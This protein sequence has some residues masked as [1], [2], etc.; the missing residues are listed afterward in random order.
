MR[1]PTSSRRASS[2]S[3][4][5]RTRTCTAA[6]RGRCASTR[7][8][9]PPRRRTQRFR[10]LLERGQT[11]LSVAFDLPT[12]IGYDSDDPRA[13]RRGRAHRRRDRLDR[14]HGA[15]VRRDPARRGLDVDDDQRARRRSCS[16]STSS[17]PRSRAFPASGSAARSRTTSSRST[18]RAGTTSSRRGPRCASSPTSSRTAP[19]ASR[20]GTRSRSRGYHI[21][22]AGSTAVQELAFTLANGIAYVRGGGRAPGSSPDDFA[23]RLSFFFNA[24]NNFFEEVAKFRAARRLWARDHARAVRRDEPEGVRRCASTRRP[25]ARRSRRSSRRTTSCA[26]RS[27]RCPRCCGGAQSLHT[28]GFDEALALPTERAARIALRTQQMIAHE[29]GG[30]DTADPLGGSYFIE[31]LTDE[32]EAKALGADRA[33]RRARRCGRGDRA[34]L[35]PGRDRAG[36]VPLAAGGRERR[37]RDRRREPVHR[38]GGGADRAPPPRSG[39]RAAPA[40]TDRTRARG[41]ECGATWSARWKRCE[42]RRAVRANLIVPMRE[43]LRAR[44]TVGEIS[45][46]LRDEFGTYDAQR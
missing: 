38:G 43:A 3:R 13:A 7:A 45:N 17:S 46:A 21:R 26:S 42:T 37:A 22:E 23:P 4:A 12:Q 36:R 27:R 40:R 20:A 14:R 29:A 11:G 1:R 18:S 8:S 30:T 39:G 2:R 16:C 19:S 31:A 5:G 15:A 32:L 24:H 35:R 10:Y 44:A 34:G 28:N 41:A 6:G 25:A 33:D 9:R